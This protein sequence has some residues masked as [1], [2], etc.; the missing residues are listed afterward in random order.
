MGH[1]AEVSGTLRDCVP[2]AGATDGGSVNG[3][4]DPVTASASQVRS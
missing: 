4:G 1:R 2:T 3:G